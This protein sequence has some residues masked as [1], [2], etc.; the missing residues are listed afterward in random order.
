M[1]DNKKLSVFLYGAWKSNL[2]D[3]LFLRAITH[4]YPDFTFHILVNRKY[5]GAYSGIGNLVSHVRDGRVTRLLNNVFRRLRKPDYIFL[6]MAKLADAVIFLGGSL[7]QQEVNWKKLYDQRSRLR[8]LFGAAFAI[9]NNFGPCTDPGMYELYKGF[10]RGMNDVCFRDRYSKDLFPY[11][12]VRS[13]SDIVFGINSFCPDNNS[14]PADAR[15]KTSYAVISVIDLDCD[16]VSRKFKNVTTVKYERWIA[17][18]VSALE[19]RGFAVV[20]MGFCGSEGDDV[21]I[22]RIIRNNHFN[23]TVKF[24]H[25]NVDESLSVLRGAGLIVATRFH[26]MI[27]GWAF[28]KKVVPIVYGNK[29]RQVIKDSAFDG[30]CVDIEQIESC[31]PLQAIDCAGQLD[32]IPRFEKDSFAQFDGFDAWTE[33]YLNGGND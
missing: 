16:S 6:K 10:F 1:R 22:D 20:L 18:L 8:S 26:A 2:G 25:S 29:M 14:S 31:D 5:S 27:I 30:Y 15:L 19:Q 13:A 24:I 33:S 7:Y 3:D 17:G 11:D 9:G 4:R 23:N 32:D 12:N 21:A 28:G